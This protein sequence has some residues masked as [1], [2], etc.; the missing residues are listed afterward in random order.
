MSNLALVAQLS[1]FFKLKFNGFDCDQRVQNWLVDWSTA[2]N[3]TLQG[4]NTLGFGMVAKISNANFDYPFFNTLEGTFFLLMLLVLRTYK[5][6]GSFINYFTPFCFST[7]CH[8]FMSFLLIS[9]SNPIL[10]QSGFFFLV[11]FGI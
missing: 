5:S 4:F 11:A 10:Q 6:Y 1:I 8:E 2:H 7:P 9:K 3:F